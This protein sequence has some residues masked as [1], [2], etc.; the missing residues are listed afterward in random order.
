[1][2]ARGVTVEICLSSNATILGVSGQ[3]HPLSAYLAAGVPVVLATD[4]AGVS[5]SSLTGEFVRAVTV[6]GIGYPEL[7]AMARR[8]LRAAFLPGPGRAALESKLEGQLAA[9]EQAL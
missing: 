8:S 4:D 1:M 9:F 3:A 2:R 6:Q 5:R 7:K